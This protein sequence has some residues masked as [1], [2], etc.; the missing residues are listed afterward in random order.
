MPT[1]QG[2]ENAQEANFCFPPQVT[3]SMCTCSTASS[4]SEARK[5]PTSNVGIRYWFLH[6]SPNFTPLSPQKASTK[7]SSLARSLPPAPITCTAFL[8]SRPHISHSPRAY[9]LSWPL[10]EDL[11]HHAEVDRFLGGHV[12]VSVHDLL[13]LLHFLRGQ[14]C[15][16]AGHTRGE[17]NPGAHAGEQRQQEGGGQK[18]DKTTQKNETKGDCAVLHHFCG[19]TREQ[20]R[21]HV[22]EA[23]AVPSPIPQP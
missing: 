9:T 22:G 19:D 10:G 3:S 11:V 16:P 15:E 7:S 18:R 13:D 21:A 14:S 23:T 2:N 5:Q 20:G 1:W 17:R 12:E 6:T 8:T 4:L